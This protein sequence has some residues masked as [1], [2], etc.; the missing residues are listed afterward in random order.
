MP[1]FTKL[2][3]C[4]LKPSSVVPKPV[5]SSTMPLKVQV[6]CCC[7]KLNQEIGMHT[8]QL[9]TVFFLRC[10][11]SGWQTR[12]RSEYPKLN[13]KWLRSDPN[14]EIGFHVGRETKT[15]ESRGEERGTVR[16]FTVLGLPKIGSVSHFF[17]F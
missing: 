5:L 9:E 11:Q 4:R 12:L 6:A 17:F 7:R 1:K 3:N 15:T 10:T 2:T 8:K 14:L 16:I 13:Y